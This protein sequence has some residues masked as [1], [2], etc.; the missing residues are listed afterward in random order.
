MKEIASEV[1]QQSA[2]TKG[3]VYNV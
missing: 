3:T 1:P 2:I